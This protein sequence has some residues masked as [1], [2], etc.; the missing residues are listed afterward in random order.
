[1]AALSPQIAAAQRAA[2]LARLT[3]VALRESPFYRRRAGRAAQGGAAAG[4]AARGAAP[5][6]AELAPFAPVGKA[7]LMQHFDDWATDRRITREAAARQLQCKD[8]LGDG[9]LGRYLLWTSSGTSGVPGWFVQDAAS[10]A[11]YDAIDALRLRGASPLRPALGAWGLAQRF[12]FIGAAGGHFAGVVSLTRLAR[13]VPLPWKPQLTLLSVQRPLDE[14]AAALQALVPDVLITYPSV[15]E[16]LAQMQQAGRLKLALSEAW[17]GGEQLSEAQRQHVTRSFGCTVRNNYGASE[18]FTI[19][20][21]CEAGTLHVNDDWVVLEPVDEQQRAVPPGELSHGVLL[22]NLAN[23]VQPLIRYRLDDRVRVL[24]E[25]CA[26]G[27]HFTAIEVQGRMADTLSLP[28]AGPA[29]G[30]QHAA[31]RPGAAHAIAIVPLALETAIEEGAQVTQF[32]IIDH[33]RGRHG[34]HT[35][36]LRFEAE[37]AEPRAAFRRCSEVIRG[38]LA[39]HGAAPPHLAFSA[40]APMRD[41]PSGKLRR[42]VA[43]DARV[44]PS[45]PR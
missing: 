33:E 41:Q 44:Q 36:E 10:L 38:Y 3:Q 22:T 24:R 19:A 16:A 34:A 40:E 43:G 7:E 18:F 42:V 35:L 30:P 5:P 13:I 1:M 26:C 6:L 11:A 4:E 32:Q 39:Q 14:L 31:R 15:A 2:R 12:A 28:A 21:Q 25:R 8:T 37:V 29:R 23:R 17:L 9:W 27:S 20:W 45:R